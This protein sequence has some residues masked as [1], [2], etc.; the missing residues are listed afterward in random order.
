M[1]LGRAVIWRWC[2]GWTGTGSAKGTTTTELTDGALAGMKTKLSGEIK[3]TLHLFAGMG[4]SRGL[5]WQ[6]PLEERARFLKPNHRRNP[7]QF[8]F[9]EARVGNRKQAEDLFVGS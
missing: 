6:V 9:V 2:S 7:K 5:R 1:V 8:S 4:L 3:K